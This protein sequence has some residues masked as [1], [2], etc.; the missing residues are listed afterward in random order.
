MIQAPP[1]TLRLSATGRSRH[2]LL[3]FPGK[4]GLAAFSL[5]ISR[6]LLISSPVWWH[7]YAL[8]SRISC[9]ASS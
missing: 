3:G 6:L 1:H 8:P 7:T 9:R 4:S 5:A 2:G